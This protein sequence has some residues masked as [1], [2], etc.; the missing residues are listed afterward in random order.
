MTYADLSIKQLSKEVAQ[1]LE[2]DE[3]DMVSDLSFVMAGCC[4]TE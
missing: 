2:F 3:R 4:N 1:D